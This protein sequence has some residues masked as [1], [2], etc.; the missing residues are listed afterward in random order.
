MLTIAG[1]SINDTIIIYDR[2]R[3]NMN[4]TKKY[5][6]KELINLSI[7]QT[8]SR[9]ILTSLTVFLV[10][11]PLFLY[12]GEVLHSFALCL[13]IGFTTGVYSSI[14]VA[15]PLVLLWEKKKV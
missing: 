4:K 6:L 5:D 1:Y 3:E 11:I 9:T 13:L 12:G 10:V 15:A 7:N 2:I 14:Y 8:L